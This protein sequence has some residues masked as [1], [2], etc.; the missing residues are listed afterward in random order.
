VLN[1]IDRLD[2]AARDQL[3]SQAARDRR[4]VPI[5]AVTGERCDALLEAIDRRLAASRQI[6]DVR[7]RHRDSS[8]IAWLY[9]HG[10]VLGRRDDAEF[11][12]LRVSLDPTDVSR[13]QRLRADAE[14]AGR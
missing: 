8:V 5:S 11:S 7:L 3:F 14:R 12:Y 1:K 13:L 9:D 10:E 4:A 6:L 2:Q